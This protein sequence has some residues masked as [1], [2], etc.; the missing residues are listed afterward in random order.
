[1]PSVGL[2]EI[3]IILIILAMFVVPV[4]LV[5]RALNRRPSVF[6]AS[7]TTDPALDALRVRLAAGEIGEAEYQRLRSVLQGG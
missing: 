2:I 3:L 6:A 4:A 7:P 5:I 1:M